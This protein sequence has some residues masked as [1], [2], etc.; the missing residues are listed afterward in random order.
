MAGS[1]I[2]RALQEKGYGKKENGGSILT[3]DRKQLNLFDTNS[4]QN[5]FDR[6]SPTV[7]ILAAAKV[8]GI[9]ANQTYPTD[10]LLDNLKIQNNVIEL[11]WKSGIKRFLFQEVV[12]FTLN[13]LN[14][15]S[16]KNIS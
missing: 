3:P 10:F 14:N 13:L 12:V 2:C 9:Y 11:A 7:T 1:A 6:N 4:V 15:L 8:G 16:K 5:W